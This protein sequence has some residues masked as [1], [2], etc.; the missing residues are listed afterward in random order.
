[1]LYGVHI[2]LQVPPCAER[3]AQG[4]PS[5]ERASHPLWGR[6]PTRGQAEQGS[7]HRGFI[8]TLDMRIALPSRFSPMRDPRILTPIL[9]GLWALDTAL[10]SPRG[11]KATIL[12]PPITTA[13]TRVQGLEGPQDVT[14]TGIQGLDH[15]EL[16]PPTGPSAPIP[17]DH[18]LRG[19]CC[20]SPQSP[21]RTPRGA[22]TLRD[23]R[24]GR[25][26]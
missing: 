24:T 10:R 14:A 16:Q 26:C 18:V 23:A 11:D 2:Q 4:Q 12:R 5:A 7:L 15:G 17:W 8:C 9:P 21:A 3:N 25:A 6:G 1:M 22:R 13:H 20:P 19:T